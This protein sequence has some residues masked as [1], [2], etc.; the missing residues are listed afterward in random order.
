MVHARTHPNRLIGVGVIFINFIFMGGPRGGFPNLHRRATAPVSAPHCHASPVSLRPRLLLAAAS[1][2]V[3]A[4]LGASAFNAGRSCLSTARQR[5]LAKIVATSRLGAALSDCAAHGPPGPSP[6]RGMHAA[7][8]LSASAAL[9][10]RWR[11]IRLLPAR[12]ATRPRPR[13]ASPPSRPRMAAML[14][15]SSV[16]VKS[17]GRLR[18]QLRS[19]RSASSCFLLIREISRADPIGEAPM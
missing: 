18:R 16:T 7:G 19:M 11:S 1:C 5:G 14:V 3:A 8:S 2:M 6:D 9:I 10:R 15:Q 12:L 17:R 13:N 4:S